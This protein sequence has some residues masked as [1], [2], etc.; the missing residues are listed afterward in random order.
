MTQYFLVPYHVLLS[1]ID[2]RGKGKTFR[3]AIIR[4]VLDIALN[5]G[6]LG[7]RLVY[8]NDKLRTI[9]R[10][11]LPEKQGK[12]WTYKNINDIFSIIAD[13]EIAEIHAEKN[14]EYIITPYTKSF[15]IK[16]EPTE[17][18]LFQDDT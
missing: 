1:E 8:S 2:H 18:L 3:N 7:K 5:C 14:S 4:L 12:E 16:A 11:D 10:P 6:S 9:F 17:S 15:S 13:T